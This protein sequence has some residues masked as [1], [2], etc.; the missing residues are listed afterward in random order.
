MRIMWE[1][2]D[3]WAF[4]LQPEGARVRHG[5]RGETKGAARDDEREYVLLTTKKTS[6]PATRL[7]SRWPP[8]GRPSGVRAGWEAEV[9]CESCRVST[10]Q[11]SHDC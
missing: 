1:R 9:G 8:A 10:M 2:D 6:L 4:N 3:E 5:R 11:R 7:G